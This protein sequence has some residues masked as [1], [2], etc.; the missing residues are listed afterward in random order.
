VGGRKVGVMKPQTARTLHAGDFDGPA[1]AGRHLRIRR[2][3]AQ[4]SRTQVWVQRLGKTVSAH[5][6]G[7][8][9]RSHVFGM[10]VWPIDQPPAS[11]CCRRCRATPAVAWATR[12]GAPGGGTERMNRRHPWERAAGV[13]SR[14]TCLKN[15]Q[16]DWPEPTRKLAQQAV[17]AGKGFVLCHCWRQPD[18]PWWYQV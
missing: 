17:E 2:G 9:S 18:W 15:D 16:M 3:A 10:E 8:V 6:S 5:A 13:P 14:P 1:A 12:A 4:R 7:D 11:P